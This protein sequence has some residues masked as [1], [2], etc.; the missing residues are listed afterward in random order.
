MRYPTVCAFGLSVVLNR[1]HEHAVIDTYVSRCQETRPMCLL[2]LRLR[3]GQ[4]LKLVIIFIS[5][6]ELTHSDQSL[7]AQQCR[8]S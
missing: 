6:C 2:R 8:T 4:L 7:Y 1:I 5:L 3:V